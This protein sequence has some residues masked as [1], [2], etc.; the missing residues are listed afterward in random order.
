MCHFNLIPTI[1]G[2]ASKL[3]KVNSRIFHCKDIK[4]CIADELSL[5]LMFSVFAKNEY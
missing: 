1:K 3:V 5:I 4:M 2:Y